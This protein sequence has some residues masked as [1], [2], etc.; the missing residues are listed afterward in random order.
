M[1]RTS[2]ILVAFGLLC[3][4]TAYGQSE[5]D[6]QRTV[7]ISASIQGSQFDIQLPIWTSSRFSVSPAFGLVFVEDAGSDY[8]FGLVGRYYLKT[9]KVSP[10]LGGRIGVL[11]ASPKNADN[12]TDVI[13][14]FLGGGEYFFDEK[15]SVGVEGQ[16]N[17]SF[18]DKKSTRFGNPGATNVN[19]AAAVFVSIYF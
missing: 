2:L 1:N 13:A 4:A 10:F 3:F 17:A 6:S 11:L 15:F 18:S 12:T 14:G 19:T 9:Q 8:R 16:V 5:S 7:G